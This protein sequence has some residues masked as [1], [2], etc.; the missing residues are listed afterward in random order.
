MSRIIERRNVAR[1]CGTVISHST[2][3]RTILGKRTK[4]VANDRLAY[5]SSYPFYAI[6]NREPLQVEKVHVGHL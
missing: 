4:A 6:N 3:K 5:P 2:V 1:A